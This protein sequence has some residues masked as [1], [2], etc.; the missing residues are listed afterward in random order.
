MTRGG[1]TIGFDRLVQC[2]RV[3]MQSEQ[4]RVMGFVKG[5]T[6]RGVTSQIGLNIYQLK[7]SVSTPIFPNTHTPGVFWCV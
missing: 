4:T 6:S 7:P 1:Y 2:E 3:A 5:G